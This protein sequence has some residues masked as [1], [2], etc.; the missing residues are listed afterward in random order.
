MKRLRRTIAATAAVSAL[1]ATCDPARAQA[2]QMRPATEIRLS[3]EPVL[4]VGSLDGPDEFLFVDI[5]GG[6]RLADGS[7][8]LSDR[9]RF[10]VQRFSAEGEHLWSRGREG[11]GPGE[12]EYVR[13]PEG[14]VGEESIIVYDIWSQRVYAYN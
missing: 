5:N 14:C 9:Q 13:I 7:V 8:V 12:F 3:I 4:S 1:A 11:E 10:R 2:T 6:A